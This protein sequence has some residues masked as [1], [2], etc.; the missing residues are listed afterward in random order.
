MEY[1]SWQTMFDE[2]RW[3]HK[4][5]KQIIRN[6]TDNDIQA[7]ETNNILT[8]PFRDQSNR[9]RRMIRLTGEGAWIRAGR[10][11]YNVH[12]QMVRS[13]CHTN[14]DKIPAQFIEVPVGLDAVVFR[15]A[16]PIPTRYADNTGFTILSAE[17][18]KHSPIYCR[19][20]LFGKV[21]N[22]DPDVVADRIRG[23][24]HGSSVAE[25]TI[26]KIIRQTYD[27]HKEISD[28]LVMCIDEGFRLKDR[29][30]ERTLCNTVMICCKPGQTI[31]EAI[32]TSVENASVKEQFMMTSMGNRLTNLLRV[33]ISSGFLANCPEDGLVVPD[34]LSNDRQA[35]QDAKKRN[36][37]NAMNTIAERAKRRGKFGYNIGTSEM[38]VAEAEAAKVGRET[39]T[40]KELSYSHIRGGHPHAVRYGE[41]KS[42]VKIKWF[43]PTRVR[44]D[45]PFKG[46]E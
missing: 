23:T 39:D 13:L 33:I 9:W 35:Y 31:S 5:E 25:K 41:G 22:E 37:Q 40:G 28:F 21:Q 29:G 34:V 24:L 20:V 14:L 18:V 32:K 7:I 1:Y 15:F 6:L 44:P 30:V 11:Y 36:D 26:D 45:L 10:P 43:R 4:D 27:E 46:G 17:D 42:K 2:Y 12:P 38:F 3:I 8:S 19:S 16:E